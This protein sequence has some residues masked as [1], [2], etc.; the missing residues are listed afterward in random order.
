MVVARETQEATRTTC[1][2]SSSPAGC[3]PI[4]ITVTLSDMSDRLL[5]AII[6]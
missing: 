6:P 5:V 4:Q 2:L 3:T 1:W